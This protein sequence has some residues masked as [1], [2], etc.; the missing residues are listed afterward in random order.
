MTSV[1]TGRAKAFADVASE[2]ARQISKHGHD[3]SHDDTHS[4]GSIAYA[5]MAFVASALKEERLADEIYPWGVG[6]DP[7]GDDRR[8]LMVKAA[9]LMIAEIERIDRAAEAKKEVTNG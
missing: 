4:D 9:A 5:A 6:F 8:T 1:M 2:R 3:E 7:H